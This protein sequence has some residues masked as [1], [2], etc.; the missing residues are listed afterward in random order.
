MNATTKDDS[1]TYFVI[2]EF[3][4]EASNWKENETYEYF[5]RWFDFHADSQCK[6][7]E[8]S[9]FSSELIENCDVYFKTGT[10]YHC[11]KCKF[12]YNPLGT[13]NTDNTTTS[14]IAS[15][16]NKCENTEKWGII[17]IFTQ[18]TSVGNTGNSRN[19]TI[20]NMLSCH[21]C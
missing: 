1:Y 9:D 13:P 12:G 2:D 4:N 17:P 7:P 6:D 19:M 14:G 8:D 5:N 15:C 11:L 18:D 16:L 20:D 10:A 21:K 3:Y